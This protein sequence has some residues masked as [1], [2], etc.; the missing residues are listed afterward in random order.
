[1]DHVRV[2]VYI[3]IYID[4]YIKK[5][6]ERKKRR[7]RRRKGMVYVRNGVKIRRRFET[8]EKKIRGDKERERE[9]DRRGLGEEEAG[10]FELG[11]AQGSG[12]WS[13]S[14]HECN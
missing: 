10:G 4:I 9:R 14:P 6:K 8:M 7:V 5:K 12:K 2:C 1:M 3:F 13:Q 11:T